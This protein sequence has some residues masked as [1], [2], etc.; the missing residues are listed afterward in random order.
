[1]RFATNAN[2]PFRSVSRSLYVTRSMTAPP[3]LVV[4]SG[5]DL[6]AIATDVERERP[7]P[8]DAVDAAHPSGRD[9]RRPRR[10]G[11][12]AGFGLKT[13]PPPRESGSARPGGDACRRV[14]A[15]PSAPRGTRRADGIAWKHP[16][17]V[18]KAGQLFSRKSI[19]RRSRRLPTESVLRRP[20]PRLLIHLRPLAFADDS[21]VRA[22]SRW[23]PADVCAAD[24]WLVGYSNGT[25]RRRNRTFQAGGCPALASFEDLQGPPQTPVPTG[26][27]LSGE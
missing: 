25:T 23:Q 27:P 4:R 19:C 20:P 18:V 11:R 12:G 8:D 2:V 6:R 10:V 14:H 17:V 22:R 26:A 16:G 3:L 24:G 21:S 1:L 15:I 13:A 7:T 9:P 5:H